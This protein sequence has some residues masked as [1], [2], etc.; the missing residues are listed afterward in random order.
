MSVRWK[1]SESKIGQKWIAVKWE[2]VIFLNTRTKNQFIDLYGDFSKIVFHLSKLRRSRKY[3]FIKSVKSEIIQPVHLLAW[4]QDRF[5]VCINLFIFIYH[6]RW[7][8]KSQLLLGKLWSWTRVLPKA[9]KTVFT[10]DFKNSR[11]W[12]H[13]LSSCHPKSSELQTP[14]PLVTLMVVFRLVAK[15]DQ[16]RLRAVLCHA[17]FQGYGWHSTPHP[18][19]STPS[20]GVLDAIQCALPTNLI[21]ETCHQNLRIVYRWQIAGASLL[22]ALEYILKTQLLFSGFRK[23][24]IILN[25]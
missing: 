16:V 2:T 20:I 11:R 8:D 1:I 6:A 18:L 19:R 4:Q 14:G 15:P 9:A 10:V 17:N 25:G 24:F 13:V 7:Y 5:V 12:S 23:I 3:T 21:Q 22:G